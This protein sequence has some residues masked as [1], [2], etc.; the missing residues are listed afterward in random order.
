VS[1]EENGNKTEVKEE[2]K[3]IKESMDEPA[4]IVDQE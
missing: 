4:K 2:I 1:T 3:E